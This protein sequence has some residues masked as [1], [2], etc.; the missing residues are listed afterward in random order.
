MPRGARKNLRIMPL[1][2]PEN[3]PYGKECPDCSSNGRP[4]GCYLAPH[5]FRD[6]PR[7]VR[8]GTGIC[9]RAQVLLLLRRQPIEPDTEEARIE[10]REG[11][12]AGRQHIAK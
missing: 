12:C 2:A 3:K 8:P 7:P 10:V 11:T 9:H 6:V 1:R 5:T 4:E